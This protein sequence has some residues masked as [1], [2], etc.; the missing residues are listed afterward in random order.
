M[1]ICSASF[2]MRQAAG[3]IDVIAVIGGGGA[4]TCE[5]RCG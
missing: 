5:P 1:A 4:A 2:T 3:R